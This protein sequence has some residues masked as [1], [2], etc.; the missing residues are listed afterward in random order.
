MRDSV[1]N[2][3]PVFKKGKKEDLGK[4]RVV[5]LTSIPG[6]GTVNPGYHFQAREEQENHH[7]LIPHV[8]GHTW[9]IVS[10]AGLPSTKRG[11]RNWRQSSGEP[12]LVKG[13]Q[14]DP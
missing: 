11:W 7:C 13:L 4:Y 12:E 2:V 8:E 6:M 1:K 9:S 14:L 3:T 10:S 5:W